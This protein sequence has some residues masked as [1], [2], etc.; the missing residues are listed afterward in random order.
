MDDELE[1]AK[2]HFYNA[3]TFVKPEYLQDSIPMC[4]PTT[5]NID[6]LPM[7]SRYPIS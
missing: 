6:G 1:K 2:A 3:A 5:H 4:F 7:I